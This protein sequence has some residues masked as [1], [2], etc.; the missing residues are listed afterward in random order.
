MTAEKDNSDRDGHLKWCNAYYDDNEDCDC[1]WHE[2][3]RRR[4]QHPQRAVTVYFHIFLWK[5]FLAGV[6]S[7]LVAGGLATSLVWWL[8][9]G[10]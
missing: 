3:L 7:G 9:G 5:T 2:E 4:Q 8:V 1:G 10:S 6:L